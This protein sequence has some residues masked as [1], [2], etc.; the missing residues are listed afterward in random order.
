MAALPLFLIS[1]DLSTRIG[2]IGRFLIE[3][4]S[5]YVNNVTK[6]YKTTRINTVD[7]YIYIIYSISLIKC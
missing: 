5:Q 2:E 6:I 4:V 1:R 7:T 3:P